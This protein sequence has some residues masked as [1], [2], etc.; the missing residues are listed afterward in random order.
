MFQ[1]THPHGVRRRA[2]YHLIILIQFQ[3]TH[4]HGV[5]RKGE[6]YGHTL[7]MFQSTHPHGVRLTAAFSRLWSFL[8]QSTHPHGVRL[9]D[10]A[11][12]Q[13]DQSFNPR[14]RMGCDALAFLSCQ[15]ILVSIHAPAWGATGWVADNG[16]IVTVSIHAPAWGATRRRWCKEP[17]NQRFNPRTRMG[18]DGKQKQ[19]KHDNSCFNPRTRMGC[20]V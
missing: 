3:S 7:L 13:K 17:R 12:K 16:D 9:K 1:S 14:T 5:R 11:R 8:F 6:L 19:K 10:Q 20:D 4:P 18:C 15:F 2:F